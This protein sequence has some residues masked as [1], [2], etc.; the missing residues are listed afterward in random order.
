MKVLCLALAVVVAVSAAPS[1]KSNAK[2]WIN[3]PG[4][5]GKMNLAILDMESRADVT[6]PYTQITF[7]LYT[8]SNRN[9]AQQIWVD[10][11]NGAPFDAAK[12]TKFI[13]HG[14]TDDGFTEWAINMKNSF[15]DQGDVNVI[16]V[17]W[18][19][20]AQGPLYNEARANVD[21]TGAYVAQMHSYLASFG[22]NVGNTHCIGHSLGAHVCGFSG[23]YATGTLGRVTGMDP[24]LPLFDIDFPEN[25][26]SDT[27][28]AYVDVIHS[29]GGWLGFEKP[30]GHSDFYPNGGSFV[31]P[32]CEGNDLTGACSH[33]RSHEFFVESIKSNG[34][35][36]RACD[37]W[38]NF[39]A[40]N[41]AGGATAVMGNPSSTS[42]R[43]VFYLAT[44]DASPFALG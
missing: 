34:F 1:A 26:L 21:P 38:D 13:I 35:V 24:A 3:I 30:L 4:V 41:C 17:D 7:H 39:V 22:H 20:P 2:K 5:D 10:N 25:R 31:Q 28:A 12:P 27:D 36:G 29:C 16:C 44:A 9:T 6:D 32:G 11:L 43:G 15:L 18:S 19:E 37:T 8:R 14:F 23:K 40:G 42:T 33:G